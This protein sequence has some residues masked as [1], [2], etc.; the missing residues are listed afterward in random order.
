MSA[1]TRALALRRLREESPVL[2]L[3]RSETMPVVAAT[4]AEHLGGQDRSLPAAEP[5]DLVDADLD[6]LRRLGFTLRRPAHDAVVDAHRRIEVL[7][8]LRE[9]W[10]RCDDALHTM[11]RA[12]KDQELLLIYEALVLLDEALREQDEVRLALEE[13]L[14]SLSRRRSR[15]DARLAGL[16]DRLAEEIGEPPAAPV[17]I[18]AGAGAVTGAGAGGEAATGAE[19][20]AEPRQVRPRDGGVGAQS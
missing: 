2:A 3:I 13:E 9:A 14:R 10:T 1:V 15:I 8:P 7:A 4:L 20:G 5:Y 6:E 16:R 12:R 17:A 19:G 11:E 18:E